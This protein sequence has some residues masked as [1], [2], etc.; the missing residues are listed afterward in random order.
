M[1]S[2]YF[3]ALFLVFSVLSVNSQ[4]NTKEVLFKIEEEP[5][6]TSEFLRVYNKNLDLVQDE[7]QKNVDEYLKLFVNYKL[8][9]REARALGFHEKP[10]YKREL[11][12]YKKQLAQNYIT[13]S[14]VTDALVKE[15]YDRML[16]EINANHILIKID[17]NAN[18]QD[19]IAAFNKITKLRNRALNEGFEKVRVEVHNGNTVFGEKLGFFGGFKM[20]YKFESAAFNTN[21]GNISK[22]FRTRFGYHIV[23]VLDKRK[24]EGERT[25][26]HIMV[27]DNVEGKSDEKAEV[28]IQDIYKKLNQGEAFEALAKQ[29]SDDK[30]S[31][32]KGGLLNPFSRGQLRVDE[33]EDVAF[34]L[35]NIDEVSKPFKTD[36]G[37]HIVKLHKIKHVPSFETYKP[38]LIEKVKRD[39]RS[40]LIDDALIKKLKEKY[41]ISNTK[42]NL[43]YF[44]SILNADYYIGKW[45]L[46]VDFKGKVHLDKIGS[47]QFN[48]NDFA[49]YLINTQKQPSSESGESLKALISKKYDLFLNEAL[50]KY[51]EDHLEEENEDY[52]HI[53][54]EYRDGLL[55]FDLMENT[56]WNAVKTDSVAIQTYYESHKDKYMQPERIDAVVA[57]SAKQKTLKKVSKLLKGGMSI[58]DV[59]SLINTNGNINV[60]FT[61]GLMD[62]QHQALPKSFQFKKGISRVFKHNDGYVLVNVKEIL[63]K[64]QKSF[65]DSKG[66]VMSDYQNNKEENWIKD[67]RE[68][69]KLEIN[70]NVLKTVKSNLKR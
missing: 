40:K 21:V 53:V 23:N 55:L 31:A 20:V 58:D 30:N 25:V 26:A 22:P 34:N 57:S 35:K 60:I 45:K 16:Y 12:S 67:L 49:V 66:I 24:S 42:P 8:K 39:T 50:I 32:P 48:Y 69:Y 37:W 59:K 47:K 6:Y 1:K 10:S 17:A 43:D 64:T 11:T 68:K 9:L 51:Q 63:E 14:K 2:K 28:R 18:P 5:V 19:T 27:V 4:S 61:S 52:A 62:S 56:I 33:F 38:E 13:D 70:Q 29:F 54:S 46:P 36:F 7:S 65:E 44:V 15:A 3:F 41:N